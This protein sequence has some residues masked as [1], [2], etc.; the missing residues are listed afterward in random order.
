IEDFVNQQI[1]EV[2]SGTVFDT[3]SQMLDIFLHGH[4]YQKAL[5]STTP[6]IDLLSKIPNLSVHEIPSGCCGMAGSFGFEKEHY[7]ISMNI[8]EEILFPEIRKISNEAIVVAPGTS[9][10]SHIFEGTGR[11]AYHTIEVIANFLNI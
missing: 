8:G 2:N 5:I 9:C 4:C 11:R 6:I 3:D 1:S 10:R 7:E